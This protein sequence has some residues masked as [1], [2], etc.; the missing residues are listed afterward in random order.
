MEDGEGSRGAEA[1]AGAVDGLPALAR[2]SGM[3][4]GPSS[5]P[6][7]ASKRTR[8]V[9]DTSSSSTYSCSHEMVTGGICCECSESVDVSSLENKN[10]YIKFEHAMQKDIY[11]KR[12]VAAKIEMEEA[13]LLIEKRK[14]S[15]VL[16][17]DHTLLHAT[18]SPY[19]RNKPHPTPPPV[20]EVIAWQDPDPRLGRLHDFQLP[21][22]NFNYYVKLRPGLFS[23][24]EEVSK[25]FVLHI[26]TFGTQEYAKKISEIIDPSKHYFHERIAAREEMQGDRDPNR[27]PEPM[28]KKLERLFPC[29]TSMVLIIDDRNDVWKSSKNLLQI[30]PCALFAFL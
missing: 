4:E 14:L 12:K 11:V 5:A 21:K 26:Y 13:R 10:K 30:Q 29:D 3:D 27:P 17:I 25:L 22:C 20:P 1:N 24:L 15:L 16:D 9:R 23:F 6:P 19:D 2:G 18:Q 28:E 7:R 8:R